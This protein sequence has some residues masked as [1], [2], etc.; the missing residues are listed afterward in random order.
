ME[1]ETTDRLKLL[2]SGVT[3]DQMSEMCREKCEYHV[4][5]VLNEEA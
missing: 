3:G 5:L 2:G 1:G 4:L